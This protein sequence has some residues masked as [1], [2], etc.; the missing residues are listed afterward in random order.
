M[1]PEL[2]NQFVQ[3]FNNGTEEEIR[4]FLIENINRFPEDVQKE[5]IWFFFEEALEKTAAWYNYVNDLKNTTN[6]LIKLRKQLEDEKKAL[7]LQKEIEKGSN[8]NEEK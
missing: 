7:E 2:Y 1:D 3:V 4:N 6:D 5:I 8:T